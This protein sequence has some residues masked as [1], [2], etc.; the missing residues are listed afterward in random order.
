[1]FVPWLRY[2][3]QRLCS[4]ILMLKEKYT[5]CVFPLDE[6]ANKAKCFRVFRASLIDEAFPLR[7]K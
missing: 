3:Y 4:V 2:C 6:M 5:S 7:Y 1:M